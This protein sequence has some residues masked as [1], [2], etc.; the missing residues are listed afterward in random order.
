MI[1]TLPEPSP[2]RALS[3]GLNS[4]PLLTADFMFEFVH[5]ETVRSTNKLGNVVI[6]IEP[7][8]VLFQPM[9]SLESLCTGDNKYNCTGGAR[10]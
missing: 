8:L 3:S 9:V 6:L 2:G 4:Q 10:S 1:T 7:I 5:T